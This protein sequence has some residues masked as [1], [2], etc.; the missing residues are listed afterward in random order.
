MKL[1]YNGFAILANNS[2]GDSEAFQNVLLSA[3]G[4]TK[5]EISDD[6][7]LVGDDGCKYLVVFEN[8]DEVADWDV[9]YKLM[10]QKV[11][12]YL[13]NSNH[14]DMVENLAY[15]ADSVHKQMDAEKKKAAAEVF[16]NSKVVSDLSELYLVRRKVHSESQADDVLMVST[17]LK[18]ANKYAKNYDV[19]FAHGKNEFYFQS[20]AEL[21]KSKS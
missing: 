5:V 20:C 9:A 1:L 19:I 14:S 8:D 7:I 10:S 13:E 11:K 21:L 17:N 15:I 2:E 3:E 16:N 6:D 12:Y 18:L 4:K